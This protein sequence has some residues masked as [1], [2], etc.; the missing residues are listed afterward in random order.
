[1]HTSWR[2]HQFIDVVLLQFK[3]ASLTTYTSSPPSYLC[4]CILMCTTEPRQFTLM[5]GRT[6]NSLGK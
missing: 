2:A 5:T 4:Y 1:M 3:A 6:I